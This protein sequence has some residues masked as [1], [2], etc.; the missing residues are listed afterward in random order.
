M[1]D[2]FDATTGTK[3]AGFQLRREKFLLP[4]GTT[5]S[6]DTFFY[7]GKLIT[8]LVGCS[9][10]LMPGVSLSV[11]IT[12]A[13]DD[14]VLLCPI[15]DIER[16]KLKLKVARLLVP[17]ATI[18]RDLF[19]R[20]QKDH[21]N[22]PVRMYFT[23]SS[24]RT[25][26]IPVH[27]SSYTSDKLFGPA[28]PTK[29]IVAFTPTSRLSNNYHANPY[30]FHRSWPKGRGSV[31]LKRVDLQLNGESVDGFD[32]TQTEHDATLPFLRLHHYLG[33]YGKQ[34]DGNHIN[35]E[36][37][38]GGYGFFVFDLSTC[39]QSGMEGL[40]PAVRTGD[41][42]LLVEFSDPIDEG[43]TIIVY[44]EHPSLIEIKKSGVVNLDYSTQ[45]A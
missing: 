42:R 32:N 36:K 21:E 9:T 2:N 18:S 6:G 39:G 38:L 10:P 30:A 33:K 44:M 19:E 25:K 41:Y 1:A 4:D 29:V 11:N 27:S 40:I 24:V 17:I 13:D 37:F 5:Y 31:Y 34:A 23:R 43:I 7:C 22:Q 20:F 14:S 12:L 16:Y 15:G 28:V 45:D 3:N 8:D 35:L 26:T